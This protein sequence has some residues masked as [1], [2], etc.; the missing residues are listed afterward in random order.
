MQA[1]RANLSPPGSSATSLRFT[2]KLQAWRW[3]AAV[4]GMLQQTVAKGTNIRCGSPGP[5]LLLQLCLP[6][7][8]DHVSEGGMV[9]PLCYAV[10][11]DA[12][13]A[14]LHVPGL[15]CLNSHA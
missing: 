5:T 11:S 10:A 7:S 2:G 6:T 15:P 8:W 3:A 14:V 1:K 9:P 12:A 13:D 4:Q